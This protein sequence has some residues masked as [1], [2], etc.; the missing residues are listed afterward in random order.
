MFTSGVAVTVTELLAPSGVAG[1]VVEVTAAPV[2]IF[3]RLAMVFTPLP[4]P[5]VAWV[6]L[7]YPNDSFTGLKYCCK[8]AIVPTDVTSL[9]ST[10]REPMP[11]QGPSATANAAA[12]LAPLPV[13]WVLPPLA[14]RYI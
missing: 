9:M 12:E 10:K 7:G 11:L 3:T 4:K 13:P 2:A 1:W 6:V 5:R 8:A 14:M